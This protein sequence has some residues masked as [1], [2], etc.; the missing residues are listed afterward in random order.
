MNLDVFYQ[1]N[2]AHFGI[3]PLFEGDIKR[4]GTSALSKKQEEKP[5]DK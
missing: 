2:S 1:S 3:K 5:L 4:K